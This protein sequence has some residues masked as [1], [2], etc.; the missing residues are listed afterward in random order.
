[1]PDATAAAWIAPADER[2]RGNVLGAAVVAARRNGRELSAIVEGADREDEAVERGR[3]TGL[4]VV[5]VLPQVMPE[6]ADAAA[7]IERARTE[8]W[9]VLLLSLGAD[10]AAASGEIPRRLASGMAGLPP[11]DASWDVPPATLRHR[12]SAAGGETFFRSGLLHVDC[13]ETVLRNAAGRTLADCEQ[14]LEWGAGC[15][16]MTAHLPGRAPAAHV[17][18]IDTDAEAVAWVGEHLP[19][20]AVEAIPLLP[21]TSLETD[22]FDVVLGHSVF[23]HLDVR[24]QDLWLEEL[25]RVTRPGGHVVVSFNGPTALEWHLRHPLVEVPESVADAVARDGVGVWTDDGWEGEF[26]DGYHTTFHRHAYVRE[27]WSRWFEPIAIEAAA[28]PPT[29]DI[30][31]LRAGPRLPAP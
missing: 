11:L 27:H 7:L 9:R 16:R 17:T 2:D 4:L 20:D 3:A 10:S 31:V 12:V 18:A 28:A 5:P 14:I 26:Y 29:Q 23:S 6:M 15:G 19:V 13:F 25:A 22:R 24:A 21:P 8:D 30:A 1:V